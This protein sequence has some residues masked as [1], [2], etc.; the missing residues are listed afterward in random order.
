MDTRSEDT[1]RWSLVGILMLTALVYL[2][3]LQFDFVF[4]DH[5]LI[6]NNPNLRSG[7]GLRP[8]LTRNLWSQHA[9]GEQG[10]YYRPVLML[11]FMATRRIAGPSPLAFHLVAVIQHLICVAL[12]FAILRRLF[13]DRTLAAASALVFALHP[14]R[15]E[16]VAWISGGNA[17]FAGAQCL[18][19]VL[20]TL[21]AVEARSSGSRLALTGA[22]MV[23][24]A[25]AILSKESAATLPG[26]IGLVVFFAGAAEAGLR[27]RLMA[28]VAAATPIALVI[29][30]GLGLRRLMLGYLSL[31]I[32][33]L[34]TGVVLR[35]IPR[36]VLGHLELLALPTTRGPFYPL[37][38]DPGLSTPAVF[39]ATALVLAVVGLSFWPKDSRRPVA[40]GWCWLGG[41]ILPV[42]NLRALPRG[43]LLHDR[44]LYLPGLGFA[45]IV[46][47]LFALA[48][49][50]AR[51]TPGRATAAL[52]GLGLT[53]AGLTMRELP[54]WRDDLELWRQAIRV[55]PGNPT[56][57][58]NRA[59][60]LAGDGQTARAERLL[61]M[62]DDGS[63]PSDSRVSA[64][65]ALAAIAIRRGDFPTAEARLDRLLSLTP[66]PRPGSLI[67]LATVQLAR[68]HL[69]AAGDTLN[70]LMELAPETR[71]ARF[72]IARLHLES[73]RPERAA[74]ACRAELRRHPDHAGARRLLE[75]IRDR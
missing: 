3:T 48:A 68:R 70:R 24:T 66:R 74:E 56:A 64:L 23:L 71:G 10:N 21:M 65:E 26:Q 20:L 73:G 57:R 29:A 67:K 9:P 18:G 2:P 17:A 43:E 75:T 40:F 46:G 8:L 37:S 36:A 16:V 41:T 60:T 72:L 42:L 32:T 34:E 50:R 33:E 62:L 27:A 47:A 59:I 45:V 63:T 30:G 58:L 13:G 12:V 5:A 55:A 11:S 31:T 15:P 49:R 19:V 39:G 61:L 69:E 28:A 4:D 22:A 14:S 53:L 6:K 7:A 25:T 51:L 44:F 35:N 38:A 1:W 52:A 54:A